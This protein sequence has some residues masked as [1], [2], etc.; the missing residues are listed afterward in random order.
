M[1]SMHVVST[2]CGVKEGKWEKGK[3]WSLNPWVVVVG[4]S[5]IIGDRTIC[6]G[7]SLWLHAWGCFGQLGRDVIAVYK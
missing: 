6:I 2:L 7:R 3:L 4:L 1:L 5:D